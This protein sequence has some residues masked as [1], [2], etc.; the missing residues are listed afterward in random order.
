MK[1]TTNSHLAEVRNGGVIPPL[2]YI[3]KWYNAQLI[4]HRA[5]L[6]KYLYYNYNEN[7]LIYVGNNSCRIIRSTR[8]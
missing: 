4:K 8:M 3:S 1:L 6:R 7:K 5:N 2:P